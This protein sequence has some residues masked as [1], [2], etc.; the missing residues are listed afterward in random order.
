MNGELL[1]TQVNLLSPSFFTAKAI[2][3]ERG[4][5]GSW[6]YSGFSDLKNLRIT[7]TN[8]LKGLDATTLLFMKNGSERR[9]HN[10]I[11]FTLGSGR[12]IN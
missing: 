12:E 10:K 11:D 6:R 8:K 5:L 3:T 7:L 2:S 4:E 9:L 1:F